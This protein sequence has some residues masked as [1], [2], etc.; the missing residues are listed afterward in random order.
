RLRTG[1]DRRRGGA[2]R[3]F[4]EDLA[5]AAD[6]PQVDG[7]PLGRHRDGGRENENES[8]R[9]R[10][11]QPEWNESWHFK[12]PFPRGMSWL[13][14]DRSPG[15]R[16]S[17]GR[18]FPGASCRPQWPAQRASGFLHPGHSGG[19]TPVS[20]RTSLDHRPNVRRRVYPATPNRLRFSWSL[21]MELPGQGA[22]LASFGDSKAAR[23]TVI[24][25]DSSP[26]SAMRALASFCSSKRK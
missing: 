26:V 25:I 15:F 7:G 22:F 6:H 20:H 24:G 18:P 4:G 2:Q 13:A 1:L 11:D 12:P 10:G 14:G 3:L 8:Q 17:V 16:E 19:T 9:A 5:A 23:A 21:A